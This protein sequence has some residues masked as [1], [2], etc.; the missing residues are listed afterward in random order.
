MK[1]IGRKYFCGFCCRLKL[2]N[3][4]CKNKMSTVAG[5]TILL[6][7]TVFLNLVAETLPQVSDAIPLLG[8]D[9]FFHI[10]LS[11]FVVIL[12]YE[13]LNL[14]FFSV[15]KKPAFLGDLLL[16]SYYYFLFIFHAAFVSE[17]Q[18]LFSFFFSFFFKL[19]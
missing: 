12:F 1:K 11:T 16:L 14:I 13:L 18:I 3:N 9:K 17:L 19:F 10:P 6:S 2:L 15:Y 5:V 8:I 7:L 4:I